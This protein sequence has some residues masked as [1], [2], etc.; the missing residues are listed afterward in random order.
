MSAA[1]VPPGRPELAR[2]TVEWWLRPHGAPR[3]AL[4]GR[5]GYYRDSMGAPGRNDVGIYDDAIALLAPDR[6]VTFNANTDPSRL[7]RGV[8]VLEPGR[9]LYRV[10]IHGLTKPKERR[11]EALV[12][13]DRVTVLRHGAARDTGWFGINIHRGGIHGTSSEGCQTIHPSQWDE[14]LA[15]VKAAL[16]AAGR[17]TIPYVLVARDDA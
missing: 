16:A 3:L 2:E 13:A 5:R 1:I 8:A 10:G 6:F 7:Y 9:W 4:L 14:F 11:Y 15:A 12:Q 17:T